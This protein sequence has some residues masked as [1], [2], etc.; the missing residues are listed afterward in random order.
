MATDL[1]G[2]TPLTY[3]PNH[4]SGLMA[5]LGPATFIVKQMLKELGLR[6][7]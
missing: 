3:D 1:I 5:G 4:G 2:L 6:E 7:K